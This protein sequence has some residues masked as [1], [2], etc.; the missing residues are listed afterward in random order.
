MSGTK[1]DAGKAPISL[2]PRESLEGT[3]SVLAF[4]AKKYAA[5]NWRGGFDW[6]RLLD[7]SYRHLTA[8]TSG[9]DLDPESGLPHVHHLACCVAFL[10]A[11]YES[12]LGKDD[13]YKAPVAQPGT[14]GELVQ[15][16]VTTGSTVKAGPIEAGDRVRVKP[17]REAGMLYKWDVEPGYTDVVHQVIGNTLYFKGATEGGVGFL[18]ERFERV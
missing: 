7:A 13:R 4:G 16:F 1:H 6:S 8:F 18:T 12:K 11:H 9:E 15:T 14:L 5:H 10:Q 2:I 3:A 17:G